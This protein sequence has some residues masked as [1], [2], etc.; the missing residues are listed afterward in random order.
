MKNHRIVLIKIFLSFSVLSLATVSG[1]E[2]TDEEKAAAFGARRPEIRQRLMEHYEKTPLE[3]K[4]LI[5]EVSDYNFG[6][7]SDI[8]LVERLLKPDA[9]PLEQLYP[10]R[11]IRLDDHTLP[12]VVNLLKVSPDDSIKSKIVWRLRDEILTGKLELSPEIEALL[13]SY[14]EGGE[15]FDPELRR[16][17]ALTLRQANELE[18]KAATEASAEVIEQDISEIPPA[19]PVE[20]VV[21]V[22]E[23]AA[24][25]PA[26]EEPAEVVV[27]EPLEEP[28]GQSSQWWL[29]LIGGVV[30]VAGIGLSVRRKR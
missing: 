13:K 22:I 24:P 8:P 18:E 27:A 1:L 6:K 29:W 2:L 5:R 21:E 14:A 25:E 16:A 30:V 9:D 10:I 19:P 28:A 4:L 23:E 7:I 3:T 15:Y 17:S 20:E 26:T 11:K 12:M